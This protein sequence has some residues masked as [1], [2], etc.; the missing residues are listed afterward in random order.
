MTAIDADDNQ[1]G[2]FKAIGKTTQVIPPNDYR[3]LKKKTRVL[4]LSIR[5]EVIK[6]KVGS[7]QW[8]APD[9]ATGTVTFYAAGN[10]ANGNGMNSVITFTQP[11]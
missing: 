5:S 6:R 3:G 1:I 4:I 2:K 7:V 8:I 11:H 9:N 10:D